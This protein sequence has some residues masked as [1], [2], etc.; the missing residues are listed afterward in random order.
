MSLKLEFVEKASQPGVQMA[1]LCREY[2]VSRQTGYK[3][4]RRH[5]EEGADGLEERSRRPKLVPLGTAEDIVMDILAAR[6]KHPRWGAKKLV[7]VLSGKWGDETPSV[8]T[9]SRVLKRQGMIRARR[10]H[11]RPMSLVHGRPNVSATAPNDVWTVDFKGWWKSLDGQ[12]CEPLTVRDAFSRFVLAVR[13][14]RTSTE[15][16]RAVFE[17]LFAKHGVPEVIQCDN[18][19]PFI[20]VQARGGLTRLSAW[21][22]SLGIRVVRSRPGCPQDNG[23]HERMHRDMRSDLQAFPTPTRRTEQ[24]ACDRWRQEFNHVRPHEALGGKTPSELYVPS[25]R[26][27]VV[28]PAAYPASW[29]TRLVSRNGMV[30]VNGTALAIGSGLKGYHIAL[31]PLGGEK[32]RIWFRDVELGF[33]DV[34]L[35]DAQLDGLLE[36]VAASSEA[37]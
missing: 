24:L 13:L 31:E 27:P 11:P 3:W 9:V 23:A 35:S 5:R 17:K 34:P 18:G 37:A 36:H 25:K 32:H 16:V 33:I 6:T 1:E 8:A 10:K 21:W 22:V 19:V 12:R 7:K 20:S 14:V 4:L 26:H 30:S 28:R 29:T 2:G 15:E